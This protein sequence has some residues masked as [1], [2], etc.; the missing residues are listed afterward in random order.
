MPDDAP[1]DAWG[2]EQAAR[3]ALRTDRAT[4]ALAEVPFRPVPGGLSNFAWRVAGA[5][6]GDCFVRYAG[7][8]GEQLGADHAVECR[9]LEQTARHGLSP[10]VVRCDPAGRLLVTRWIDATGVGRPLRRTV[11]EGVITVLIP[12]RP[13]AGFR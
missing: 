6:A 4:A 13:S 8:F 11:A 1:L 2:A 7:R 10:P 3:V 12:P 9:V 5:C